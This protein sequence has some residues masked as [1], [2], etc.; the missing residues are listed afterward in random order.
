[1]IRKESSTRTDDPVEALFTRFREAYLVGEAEDPEQFLD[2]H[3]CCDP[4]L[5]T[6]IDNFLRVMR[7]LPEP[8]CPELL[9][10]VVPAWDSS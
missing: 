2:R 8:S 5:R 6:R 4:E 7:A 1:M 9:A 3:A 10:S